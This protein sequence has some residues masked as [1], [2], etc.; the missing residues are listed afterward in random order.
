VLY[1]VVPVVSGAAPAD[2][3]KSST[4][5]EAIP[6]TPAVNLEKPDLLIDDLRSRLMDMGGARVS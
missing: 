4:H 3:A 2:T 1:V 5:S 6:T